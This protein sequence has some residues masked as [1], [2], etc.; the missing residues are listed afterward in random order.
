[1]ETGK[2]SVR[3]GKEGFDDVLTEVDLHGTA[4]L[5][6]SLKITAPETRI[7]VSEKSAAVANSDAAYRQLR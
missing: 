3:V 4:D 5:A 1:L 6:L 7:T 2:Y